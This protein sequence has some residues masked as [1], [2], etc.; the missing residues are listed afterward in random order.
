[1]RRTI[2][3]QRARL[4]RE[5]PIVDI[6]AVPEVG[7]ADRRRIGGL[8]DRLAQALPGVEL[9]TPQFLGIVEGRVGLPQATC[10]GGGIGRVGAGPDGNGAIA[11]GLE[12]ASLE[13]RLRGLATS[14]ARGQRGR[15]LLG[16]GRVG[17]R[18][19]RLRRQAGEGA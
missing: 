12:V 7:W 8:A 19:G 2:Y 15:L 17:L 4:Q 5:I 13:P 18:C 11:P 1:M 6:G 10:A 14:T 3:E 9:L 16:V